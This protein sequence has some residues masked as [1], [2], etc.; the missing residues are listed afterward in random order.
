MPARFTRLIVASILVCELLATSCVN[1]R[2]HGLSL[3]RPGSS[4]ILISI[5]TLRADH[6]SAYGYHRDTSPTI[7]RLAEEGCSSSRPTATH[8]RPPSRT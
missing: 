7:D 5:D 2:S 8:P 3:T 1:K 4:V 6:L